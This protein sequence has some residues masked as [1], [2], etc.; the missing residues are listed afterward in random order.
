MAA[1]EVVVA[2]HAEGIDA[3]KRSASGAGARFQIWVPQ[4]SA[5]RALRVL[6]G[7]ELPRRRSENVQQGL[8]GSLL[9]SRNQD[10]L[11]VARAL[12]ASLE[13]SLES[14]DRVL[15]ASV[16]VSLPERRS[17]LDSPPASARASVLLRFRGLA[18]PLEPNEIRRLV[19]GAVEHLEEGAVAVVLKRAP[20]PPSPARPA[21]ARFGPVET[22]TESLP[23]LRALTAAIASLNAAMA[24]LLWFVWRRWK[25]KLSHEPP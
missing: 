11:R 6:V 25:R 20:E 8:G 16:H 15:Q 24:T 5:S 4:G 7:N 10:R 21:R 22:T 13:T 12:G 3:E 17:A 14:V 2:L 23:W 9:P 19:S 1:N 18:P